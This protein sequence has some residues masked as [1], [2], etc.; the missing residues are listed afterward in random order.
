LD[1]VDEE[2][3]GKGREGVTKGGGLLTYIGLLAVLPG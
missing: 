1:D 3:I 2:G